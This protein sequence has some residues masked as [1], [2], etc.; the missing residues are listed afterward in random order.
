MLFFRSKDN[1]IYR[2]NKILSISINLENDSLI[3]KNEGNAPYNDGLKINFEK[4]GILNT[5]TKQINLAVNGI[6]TLSL[7]GDGV[8]NLKIEERNNTIHFS[9]ITLTGGAAGIK[10][11]FNFS[12]ILAASFILLIIILFAISFIKRK[13]DRREKEI[14]IKKIELTQSQVE[15][16]EEQ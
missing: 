16:A 10:G 14:E 15:K 1:E 5:I 2:N 13:K 6:L 3:I 12:Y 8:Y 9:G 11:N 4:D 7:K